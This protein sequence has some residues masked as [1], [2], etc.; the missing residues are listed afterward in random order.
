[1]IEH[2]KKKQQLQQFID[3]RIQTLEQMKTLWDRIG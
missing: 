3:K 2:E 1:M